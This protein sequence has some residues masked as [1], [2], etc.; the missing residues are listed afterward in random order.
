MV[1][2]VVVVLF[3]YELFLVLLIIV[4][5]CGSCRLVGLGKVLLGVYCLFLKVVDVIISL[6]VDFGGFNVL[7]S[8]WLISG[9]FWVVSSCL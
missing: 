8:V 6:K 5:F 2:I 7:V 3:L 4:E 9:L 1:E